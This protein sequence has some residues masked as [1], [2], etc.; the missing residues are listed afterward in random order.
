M[1]VVL[2]IIGFRKGKEYYD[3]RKEEIEVEEKEDTDRLRLIRM[4][5]TEENVKVTQ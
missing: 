2:A 1:R 4:L 3:K 5:P